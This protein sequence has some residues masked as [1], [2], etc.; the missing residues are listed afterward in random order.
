MAEIKVPVIIDGVK[1]I[2]ELAERTLDEYEYKGRT[3]RQWADTICEFG[4]KVLV[5]RCKDCKYARKPDR[6]KWIE[7]VACEGTL[8]CCVGFEHVWPSSSDGLIFVD[9]D[10]Y[11]GQGERRDGDG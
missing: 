10:H 1:S 5:V 11:C 4:D 2:Q 6:D 8:V 7:N 9:R 3:L